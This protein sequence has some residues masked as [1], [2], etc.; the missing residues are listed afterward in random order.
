MQKELSASDNSFFFGFYGASVSKGAGVGSANKT[1]I[2]ALRISVVR[3]RGGVDNALYRAVGDRNGQQ[4][5][6]VGK[7]PAGV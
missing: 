2:R 3:D 4:R 1:G 5:R 6:A 7:I